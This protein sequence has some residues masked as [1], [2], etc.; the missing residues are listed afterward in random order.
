MSIGV[1]I[2]QSGGNS[3]VVESG[4]AD[5]Y[6]VVLNSQPTA[7]VVISLD[8]T[9][10]QVATN[11]TQLTFTPANW[12]VPQTVT[13]TASNDKMGEGRHGSHSAFG[14]QH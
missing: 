11:V 14:F 8:N 1:T 10:R 5:S 9:N 13:L 3:T 12:S 6:T 7:N 4:L 2:T